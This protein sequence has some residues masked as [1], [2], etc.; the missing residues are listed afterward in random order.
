MD[1]EPASLGR[2]PFSVRHNRFRNTLRSSDWDEFI[3]LV[4]D[5]QKIQFVYGRLLAEDDTAT[6]GD[7]DDE[8]NSCKNGDKALEMKKLGTE[9]FQNT[10]YRKA[11]NWYSLAVLHCPQTKGMLCDTYRESKVYSESY[12]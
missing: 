1:D 9:C 4:D 6:N 11:L 8:R 12:F 7:D 5:K 10:D 2:K 3:G